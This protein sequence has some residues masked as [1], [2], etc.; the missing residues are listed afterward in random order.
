MS[1]LDRNTDAQLLSP[2]R[3]LMV[4]SRTTAEEVW[5]SCPEIKQLLRLTR[6][7][8]FGQ[9]LDTLEMEHRATNALAAHGRGH[10]SDTRADE[11][12]LAA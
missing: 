8:A 4:A 5:S 11:P 3:R 7:G 6:P 2:R 12:G 9:H 10:A 1:Q